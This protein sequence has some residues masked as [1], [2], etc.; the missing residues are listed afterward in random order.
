MLPSVLERIWSQ[1]RSVVFNWKLQRTIISFHH[2]FFPEENLTNHYQVY[3]HSL[4]EWKS[5]KKKG[6]DSGDRKEGWGG[7]G[8]GLKRR[9][10]IFKAL[11]CLQMCSCINCRAPKR[12]ANK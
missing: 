3:F 9:L 4:V 1:S 10:A 7:G 2:Y 11:E 6:K 5:E 12:E 8:G